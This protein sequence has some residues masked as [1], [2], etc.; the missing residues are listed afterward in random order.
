MK[1]TDILVINPGST[2]T[3]IG[4]FRDMKLLFEKTITHD[5]DKL[6]AYGTIG[7]QMPYRTQL[8]KDFLA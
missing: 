8:I 7:A 3:K 6:L 1:K 4:V 2:T 5:P